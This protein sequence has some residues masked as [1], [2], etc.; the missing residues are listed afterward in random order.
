M[1]REYRETLGKTEKEAEQEAEKIVAQGKK[2]AED[3][4]H[5]HQGKIENVAAWVAKEVVDRYGGSKG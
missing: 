5:R 4:V 1:H 3:L 2:E